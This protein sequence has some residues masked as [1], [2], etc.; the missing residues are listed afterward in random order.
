MN[1][2]EFEDY[3]AQIQED[4]ID[5]LFNGDQCLVSKDEAKRVI[6]SVDGSSSS[7]S[8]DSNVRFILGK[9]SPV[10]L[11]PGIYATRLVVEIQCRALFNVER[12]TTYKLIRLFCAN[13]N[14]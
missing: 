2:K 1:S 12:T 3:V 8:V 7:I 10:L 9:C 5:L 14:A 6:Q 13:L 4:D 11:V